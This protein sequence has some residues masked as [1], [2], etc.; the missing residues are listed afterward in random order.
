MEAPSG[1]RLRGKGRHGVLCRLKAVLSMPERF[2]M[3]YHARR[4]ISALLYFF[5]QC[6]NYF[7]YNYIGLQQSLLGYIIVLVLICTCNVKWDMFGKTG[8][9]SRFLNWGVPVLSNPS[10]FTSS[11]CVNSYA[12]CPS[13]PALIDIHFYGPGTH[14]VKL[15][16]D[17][18]SLHICLKLYC[19]LQKNK[20][21]PGIAEVTYLLVCFSECRQVR[22]SGEPLL[23]YRTNEYKKLHSLQSLVRT[24]HRTKTANITKDDTTSASHRQKVTVLQK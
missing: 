19:K 24:N 12:Y 2:N 4:Y 18:T 23:C 16:L 13:I 22:G 6:M 3:V 21:C 15:C 9:V 7:F 14:G 11:G 1:E 20:K 17:V 5:L 8:T 10:H